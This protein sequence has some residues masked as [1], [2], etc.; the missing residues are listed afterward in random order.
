MSAMDTVYTLAPYA[1]VF[2]L[3]WYAGAKASGYFSSGTNVQTK[4]K[5]LVENGPIFSTSD[6]PQ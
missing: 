2:T 4:G 3:G 6:E 1:F 5:F